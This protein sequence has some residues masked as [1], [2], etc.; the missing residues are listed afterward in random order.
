MVLKSLNPNLSEKQIECV[1]SII[2]PI[3]VLAGPGTGKTFTVIQRLKYMLSEKAIAPQ[4]ILCLTFSETA[5]KE[6]RERLETEVGELASG[7]TISTYH[8]FCNEII[9]KYPSYFDMAE[10]VNLVDEI[11]KYRIMHEIFEATNPEFLR[12]EKGDIYHY[13]KPAISAVSE[14]KKTRTSKEMY[15]EI[16]ETSLAFGGGLKEVLEE[17]EER[18]YNKKK[19]TQK[20]LKSIESFQKNIAKAKNIWQIFELYSK[21]LKEKNYIDFDDMINFVLDIFEKNP[22][23][24]SKV[25]AQ[26]QYF[27]V[28]EY[29]DTNFAQNQLVFNLSEGSKSNNV[30]VVGDDDQIIYGFQGAQSDNLEK[31][32]RH[33]PE[34]KVICLE[35]NFRSTQNILDLSYEVI[36][37]DTSRIEFNPEFSKFGISKKLFSKNESLKNLNSKINLYGFSENTQEKNFIV[38]E[39]E[40]IINSDDCPQKNGIKNLSEIAILVKQ[41]NLAKE[42]MNLLKL[43][44]IPSQLTKNKH[45]FEIEASIV[46]IFYLKALCNPDIHSDKLFAIPMCHPFD[47]NP[48]DYS[49]LLE[50]TRA[51][52]SLNF[53]STIKKYLNNDWKESEKIKK[54]V[55]TYDELKEKVSKSDLKNLIKEVIEK[56]GIL[57]FYNNSEIDNEDNLNALE[58]LI[59]EAWSFQKIHKSIFLNE[60]L[61]HLNIAY[62]NELSI[63]ISKNESKQNA[64]QLMSL[65]G[66]KGR[67][68]EYVFISELC[69]KKWEKYNNPEQLKVPANKT[70]FEKK[71]EQLRLLFVGMTRAKHKLYMTFPTLINQRPHELTEYIDAISSQNPL[72]QSQIFTPENGFM[73]EKGRSLK[74]LNFDYKI[75]L[76]KELKEEIK[77]I[78]LSPSSIATYEKCP[79]QFL[80]SNVYRIPSKQFDTKEMNYGN[81][82]HKTLEE[83]SVFKDEKYNYLN[84]ILTIFEKNINEME[85]KNTLIEETLLARGQKALKEFLPHFSPQKIDEAEYSLGTIELEEIKLTGK[86]DRIEINNDGTYFLIDYKT[87]KSLGSGKMAYDKHIDQIRFYKLAFELKNPTKK[88]SRVGIIYVEDFE[89][90]YIQEVCEEDDILIKEKILNTYANIQNLEFEAICNKQSSDICKRCNYKLLCKI[91]VI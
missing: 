29:Q 57:E 20:I 25:S 65:H 51:D 73:E 88:V 54:F 56:T 77:K 43:K 75:H 82:I 45:V 35:N 52:K 44:G 15:F 85:L 14:I 2:G 34:A 91:N 74:N 86:I 60:F 39:I 46:T 9:A 89:K 71:S 64:V 33:Y 55:E 41:N 83:A 53:I 80:Y 28:D 10:G 22:E 24:L 76:G 23:F 17:K 66:S 12:T 78:K 42:F 59:E 49:F 11:T 63:E 36:S 61:E 38:A 72:I 13:I 31:F 6:M 90:N 70:A 69:A 68:F 16:L 40:K 7:I 26:Y 4:S 30:F 5:A 18:E 87:G 37:Q 58:K 48:Y 67:E 79:R 50:K 81:A 21:K 27:L 32:L 3:M 62:Q 47:F 84:E 8:S 19:V 1:N